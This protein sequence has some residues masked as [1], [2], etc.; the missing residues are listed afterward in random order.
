MI[1]LPAK[2][3]I[4]IENGTALFLGWFLSNGVL[5]ITA[6]DLPDSNSGGRVNSLRI[7]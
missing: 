4:R 3:I 5:T 7:V 1:T 2:L 6:P